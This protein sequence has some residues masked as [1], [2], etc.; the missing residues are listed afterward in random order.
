M[1]QEPQN[2]TLCL[3]RPHTAIAIDDAPF[4][5]CFNMMFSNTKNCYYYTALEIY[6]N[7]DIIILIKAS[8]FTLVA[9]SIPIPLY[10]LLH[11]YQ[12]I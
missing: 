4:I 2:I 12:K 8:S 6:P 1:K 10:V 3:D 7:L 11:M 5:Q 9:P